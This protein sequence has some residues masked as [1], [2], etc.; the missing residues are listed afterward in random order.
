VKGNLGEAICFA[1][2]KAEDFSACISAV[3]NALNPF[4]QISRANID[5]VWL[6]IGSSGADTWAALQEV[7]T[8]AS[9]TL[10][11]ANDL[12]AEYAQLF[13]TDPQF[14][15][16]TRL[17]AIAND[18]RYA[19]NASTSTAS[20]V[21]GLAGR[22]PQ[23]TSRVSLIPSLVHDRTTAPNP[24]PKMAGVRQAVIAQG[25]NAQSVVTWIVS[26]ADLDA[27]LGRLRAGRP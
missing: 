13:G 22:N 9:S 20:L 6:H 14:T 4:S 17:Q 7:K 25:W 8:T 16:H 19:Q 27:R 26:I 2:G 3:P 15:L 18:L 5:I 21:R 23:T 1:I 24:T 11:L 12:I 10:A